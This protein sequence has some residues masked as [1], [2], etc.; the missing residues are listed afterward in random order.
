MRD[1]LSVG[2]AEYV[3]NGPTAES[4]SQYALYESSEELMAMCL[5]YPHLLQLV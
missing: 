2:Y 1:S 4:V 3:M 5:C